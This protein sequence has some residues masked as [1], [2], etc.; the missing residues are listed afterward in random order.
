MADDALCLMPATELAAAI[1]DRRLSPVELVE[2]VLA[3]IDRLN[4]RL[5]AYLTVADVQ[6]RQGRGRRKRR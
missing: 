4:P 1:R 3:R 6:A 2:A 5:N